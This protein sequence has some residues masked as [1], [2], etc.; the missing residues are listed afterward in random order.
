MLSKGKII[1]MAIVLAVLVIV[2][3]SAE[4]ANSTDTVMADDLQITT[5]A[6]STTHAV[7]GNTFADIQNAID[8]AKEGD[9]IELSGDYVGNGSEIRIDKA[10]DIQGK[11]K[12]TLDADKKSSIF[13]VFSRNTNIYQIYSSSTA[14]EVQ[15]TLLR[16]IHLSV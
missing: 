4:D 3:V 2:P 6:L 14:A 1:L 10:L 5:E 16:F 9:T 11:G 12:T 15:S 7:S 13:S 8:N